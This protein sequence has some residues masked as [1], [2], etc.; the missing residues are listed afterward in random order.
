MP[1]TSTMC[2]ATSWRCP[3]T[4]PLC[5]VQ[6]IRGPQG[7]SVSLPCHRRS[8]KGHEGTSGGRGLSGTCPEEIKMK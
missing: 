5:V 7:C 8:S 3:G 4:A 6:A 1:R 2:C